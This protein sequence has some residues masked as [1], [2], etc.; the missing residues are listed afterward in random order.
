MRGVATPLR[1]SVIETP[2]ARSAP[3][4]VATDA[5]GTFC[6]RIAHAPVT[7]GVDSEVPEAT[8]ICVPGNA[9]AICSPGASSDRKDAESEK[10]EIWSPAV[11]EPTLTADEM[12]PGD[13]SA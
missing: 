1:G 12:Q 13:S 6:L 3:S 5:V 2:V 10:D 7:C 4:T 8:S 11:V 9:D